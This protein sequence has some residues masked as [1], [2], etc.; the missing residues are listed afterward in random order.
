VA[1]GKQ[2]SAL[3]DPAQRG[4]TAAPVAQ[5]LSGGNR[6]GHARAVSRWFAT[7]GPLRRAPV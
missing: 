5:A 1:S 4:P 6:S 3:G 2:G 7:N